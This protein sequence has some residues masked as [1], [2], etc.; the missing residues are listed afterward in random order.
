MARHREPAPAPPAL[1]STRE[2]NALAASGQARPIS[3]VA[4]IIMRYRDSWW[5]ATSA[6]WLPVA[7]ALAAVLDQHAQRLQ[8]HDAAIANSHATIRAVLDLTAGVPAAGDSHD[9]AR[10][11]GPEGASGT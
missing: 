9:Q 11:P 7:P 3:Q 10:Q 4:Q 5:L 6:G 2:M 1:I 8:H